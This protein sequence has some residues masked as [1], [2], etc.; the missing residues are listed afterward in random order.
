MAKNLHEVILANLDGATNGAGRPL[1]EYRMRVERLPDGVLA[2]CVA[3]AGFES[4][5]A[6]FGIDGAT[7]TDEASIADAR[8]KIAAARL[9][10][11]EALD[12][13]AI[14]QLAALGMASAEDEAKLK[15]AQPVTTIKDT[16]Q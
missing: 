8:A 15:A 3:P 9:A 16:T 6:V 12:Q 2:I 13:K 14:E 5:E 10:E 11:Q 4:Q 7:L 1:A